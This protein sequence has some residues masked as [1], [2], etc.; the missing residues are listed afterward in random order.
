MNQ[1]HMEKHNVAQKSMFY[2]IWHYIFLHNQTVARQTNKY[3]QC[4]SVTLLI[5]RRASI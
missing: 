3:I 1:K 2:Y 4:N 5:Y